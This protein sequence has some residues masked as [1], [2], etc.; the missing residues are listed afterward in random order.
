MCTKRRSTV[1]AL[2]ALTTLSASATAQER[3]AR[4]FDVPTSTQTSA[5]DLVV[6][7]LPQ[8]PAR[9]PAI[10]PVSLGVPTISEPGSPTFDAC[11]NGRY[12]LGVPG[13]GC[14]RWW[15]R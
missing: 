2:A 13:V 14:G 8:N 7:A 11:P 9:V 5:A 10:A 6:R 15:W 4:P 12:A 3:L 1:L